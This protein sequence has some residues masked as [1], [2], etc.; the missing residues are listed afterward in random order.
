MASSLIP[1]YTLSDI[2]HLKATQIEKL[3]SCELTIDGEY[4]CTLI[5]PPKNGGMTILDSC[6][7]RAEQVAVSANSVGG[8]TLQ[9]VRDMI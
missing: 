1:T 3:K 4:L 9:E 6:K 2:K 8:K 7:T 5:I